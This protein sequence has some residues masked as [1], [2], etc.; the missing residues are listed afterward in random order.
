MRTFPGNREN[1]LRPVRSRETG[2]P[3]IALARRNAA[4]CVQDLHVQSEF[5][6]REAKISVDYK[7]VLL[8]ADSASVFVRAKHAPWS[9]DRSFAHD[10]VIPAQVLLKDMSIGNG[11]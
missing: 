3:S 11:K 6:L 8:G 10:H 9:K 1:D 2:F 7:K 4:K 5:C